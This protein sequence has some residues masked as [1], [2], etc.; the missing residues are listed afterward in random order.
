MSQTSRNMKLESS[1]TFTQAMD[2]VIAG[3]ARA[4]SAN[5]Q[6]LREKLFPPEAKKQLRRFSSGEAAKLIGVTDNN[7]R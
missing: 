7:R 2:E 4:L 3:D 6:M 5:L 1:T